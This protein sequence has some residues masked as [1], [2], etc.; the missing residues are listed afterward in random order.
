MVESKG[1]NRLS[2]S[3]IHAGAVVRLELEEVRAPDGS[4]HRL[5]IVRYAGAAAVVALTDDGKVVLVR[6]FRPVV[7]EMIG[8]PGGSRTIEP[9]KLCK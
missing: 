1:W 3:T 7:G 5:E 2:K 6:Q 9:H 4:E 8:I